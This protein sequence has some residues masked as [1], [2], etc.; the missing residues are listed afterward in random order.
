MYAVIPEVL[1]ASLE[2]EFTLPSL[3][4]VRAR[5][6]KLTSDCEPVMRRLVRV[7]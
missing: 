3:E 7:F 2:A 5:L 1:W 4:Q 6:E